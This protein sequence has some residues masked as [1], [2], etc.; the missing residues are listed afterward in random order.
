MQDF[1]SEVIDR[2]HQIPVVV[3]FW[4]PW[5]GPCRVLGPVIEQIANDQKGQW[6]L[7]K[8]NTEENEE[9]AYEYRIQSIPN[10]KMFYKGEVIADFLGALP[11]SSIE[12]WL[13]ENLPDER[14]QQLAAIQ[15]AIAQ[16][17]NS[18]V[19]KALKTFVSRYPDFQPGK[20][21]LAKQIAFDEAEKA[22]EL[23]NTL[24]MGEDGYNEAQ[25]IKTIQEFFFLQ[26][27]DSPVAKKLMDAQPLLKQ[28]S[29][30]EAIDLIINAV[31]I[32][33]DYQNGLPRKLAISIFRLLGDNHP[34]TKKFR[35][36]FDMALY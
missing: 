29:F 8:V 10:V 17:E 13:S 21:L 18:D 24:R 19:L 25:D 16:G 9:L 14:K 32:N 15:T 26:A 27:E 20:L 4:A 28:K 12:N 3:D 33:K 35:R 36:K 11:K 23:T 6:E 7:V 5:C 1:Q 34:V 30:E 22:V 31:M 2:S